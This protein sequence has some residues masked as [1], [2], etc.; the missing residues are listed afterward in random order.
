ML[1]CFFFFKEILFFLP[2]YN[3]SQIGK[4]LKKSKSVI[5][6]SAIN[7]LA[8]GKQSIKCAL[9][10]QQKIKQNK[11]G[12]SNKILFFFIS[13]FGLTFSVIIKGA[14]L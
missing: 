14:S 8:N 11:K 12:S 10:N 2:N 5:I 7:A 9:E 13:I 4:A 3:R 6:E 1:R